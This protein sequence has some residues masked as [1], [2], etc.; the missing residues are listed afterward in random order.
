MN[1]QFDEQGRIFLHDPSKNH[2]DAANKALYLS[3]SFDWF[4]GDFTTLSGTIEKFITPY[5]SESDRQVIANDG[6]SIN[7]TDCNR[8]LNKQ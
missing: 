4:K 5:V 8:T 2:L 7:S 3:M 6:L 1:C